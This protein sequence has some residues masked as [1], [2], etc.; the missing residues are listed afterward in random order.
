MVTKELGRRVNA[1]LGIEHKW[2]ISLEA[3]ENAQL[4]ELEDM[5]VNVTMMRPMATLKDDLCASSKETC[6]STTKDPLKL[7]RALERCENTAPG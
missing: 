2:K 5:D 3:L 4:N 7:A 6:V 1:E